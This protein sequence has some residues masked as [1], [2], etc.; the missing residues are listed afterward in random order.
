MLT[1]PSFKSSHARIIWEMVHKVL[2]CL[3]GYVLSSLA[4]P[5]PQAYPSSYLQEAY[6]EFTLI[7]VLG[8]TCWWWL[9]NSCFS[10]TFFLCFWQRYPTKPPSKPPQHKPTPYP[11]PKVS[12]RTAVS[13]HCMRSNLLSK[14]LWLCNSNLP[15]FSVVMQPTP[16]PSKHPTKPPQHKP[17]PYPVCCNW[18][19]RS[20]KTVLPLPKVVLTFPFSFSF[21]F[22]QHLIQ[23]TTRNQLP[24]QALGLQNILNPR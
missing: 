6:S 1:L 12:T 24:S 22:H 19:W 4:H 8:R 14:L 2:Q 13:T 16:K 18:A 9:F 5:L 15:C 7:F 20:D 23:H 11:A 17:T 3:T 10:G 21:T